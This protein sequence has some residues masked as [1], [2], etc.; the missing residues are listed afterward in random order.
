VKTS[1]LTKD[2]YIYKK[3]RLTGFLSE[4]FIVFT[5]NVG[6]NV[7]RRWTI[8]MSRVNSEYFREGGRPR[9]FKREQN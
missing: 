8:V 3:T 1:N 2:L 5:L 7:C 4:H 6:S 9:P